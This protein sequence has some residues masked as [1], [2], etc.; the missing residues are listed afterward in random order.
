MTTSGLKS[1]SLQCLETARGSK[2]RASL[3]S[4]IYDLSL[5]CQGELL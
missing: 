5:S 2:R 4:L 1:K 3:L